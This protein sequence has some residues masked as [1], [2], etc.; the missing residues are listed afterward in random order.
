MP[1]RWRVGCALGGGMM[2]FTGALLGYDSIYWEASLVEQL[3]TVTMGGLGLGML[4]AA[5][6]PRD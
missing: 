5:F 3:P 4:A 6:L 1:A 2:F